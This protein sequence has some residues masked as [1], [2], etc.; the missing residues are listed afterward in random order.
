MT[1]KSRRRRVRQGLAGAGSQGV[2]GREGVLERCSQLQGR[3]QPSGPARAG[4]AISVLIKVRPPRPPRPRPRPSYL[5]IAIK[6]PTR[7]ASA[8]RTQQPPAP[9][10]PGDTRGMGSCS[11]LRRGQ[12][13]VC[14]RASFST[15]PTLSKHRWGGNAGPNLDP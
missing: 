14:V 3:L 2:A 10:S 13:C 1:G 8:K 6:S 12:E 5:P 4:A 9:R 11:E 15:S 7:C